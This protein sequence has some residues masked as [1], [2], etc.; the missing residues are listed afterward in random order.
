MAT[1][2]QQESFLQK[3]VPLAQEQC[4]KH[5]G[6]VFASV[7]IAQAIHESGWGTAQK[8]ANAN[9]V[10]G[11]KVGKSAY[12]FG[13]AWKGKAYKTGT[14]EYYDGVNP[15]KIVDYFR[16]YDSLAES[17][18]DYYDM[19]C[20][21]ERY[22]GALNRKTPQ[23]CIQG[24]IDGGYATGPAYVQHIMD[25]INGRN[26]TQY[27]EGD[28][29]PKTGNPYDEPVA[30]IRHNM[31]GNGVRWVQYQL[32]L[33]GYKLIVDGIAGNMTIGAVL[34]F[35]RRNGL[36]IDGIVGPKTRQKLAEL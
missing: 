20:H 9:A 26:L 17:V 3:I 35:Q 7:C 12:K 4:K 5:S 36:K 15:T 32:N 13:T 28:F 34:D 1:K 29:K 2:A 6:K 33:Y 25:I 11:I 16:A 21:C 10:F 8:M 31:K 27:D 14:T 24:I 23:E 18:E 30:T 19:L 22:K